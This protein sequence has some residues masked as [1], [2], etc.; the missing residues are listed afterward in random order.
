MEDIKLFRKCIYCGTPLTLLESCRGDDIS[1]K[2]YLVIKCLECHQYPAEEIARLDE[3][4]F[5]LYKEKRKW[6]FHSHYG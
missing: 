5:N 1:Q 4:Q 2:S 3:N 6:H